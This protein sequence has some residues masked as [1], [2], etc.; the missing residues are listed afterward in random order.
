MK[1]TIKQLEEEIVM[2][3]DK[4]QGY[5]DRCYDFQKAEEKRKQN[6]MFALKSE[7]GELANQVRNLMEII[8]WQVRPNTAETPF[9]PTKDQRDER[10]SY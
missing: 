5:A 4:A 7:N 1:K 3:K 2:L 8:R 10:K 9:M 6:E